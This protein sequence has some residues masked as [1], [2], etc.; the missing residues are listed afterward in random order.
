MI[1]STYTHSAVPEQAHAEEVS[2]YEDIHTTPKRPWVAIVAN[3]YSG[4]RSNR[5]RVAEL[6][7]SLEQLGLAARVTWTPEDRRVLLAQPN[8]REWCRCIVI[9][10]GDGTIGDVVNIQRSVPVAV[11]PLG[12]ENLFARHYGYTR[13]AEALVAAITN[14]QAQPIDLGRANDRYFTCMLTVGLDADV[15]HRVA[16]WRNAKRN[17]N[18]V[19]NTQTTRQSLASVAQRKVNHLSY[20]KPIINSLRRYPYPQLTVDTGSVKLHGVAAMVFNLPQYALGLPFASDA[21]DDDGQLDYV[22]F[23]HA[24]RLHSLRYLWL[25]W[26]NLHHKRAG[27]HHGR[28][29]RLTIT[30]DDPRH[31][32][33]IQ[34]DG[35]PAGYT[36]VNVTTARRTLRVI[37]V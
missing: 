9:A 34:L 30:C 22:I 21:R 14:G 5:P 36:P 12:N 37:T 16:A 28:C 35:D 29:E 31:T 18:A 7:S 3:P 25:V 23:T 13:R 19:G 26:R 1:P 6:V 17:G 20:A 24:G 2:S 15:V 4:P 33:P 27:I 8:L 32:A 10:G 11:F